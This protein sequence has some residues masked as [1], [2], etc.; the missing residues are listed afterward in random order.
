MLH[1]EDL[2]KYFVVGFPDNWNTIYIV[3]S[4][5]KKNITRSLMKMIVKKSEYCRKFV[6]IGILYGCFPVGGIA[7]TLEIKKA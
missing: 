1:V 7:Y 4:D 2:A 5:R 6:R 3:N